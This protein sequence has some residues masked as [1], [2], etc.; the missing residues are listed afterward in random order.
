MHG[1]GNDFVVIDGR[2]SVVD[3]SVDFLRWLA[4]RKRGVGCDQVI[5]LQK[6]ASPL[7]DVHM[8]IFNLDGSQ[9]RA[10]GNATRCVARL[11]FGELGRTTCTIET[12]AALLPAWQEKESQISVDF[13]PPSLA[14]RDIPLAYESDTLRTPVRCGDLSG[15]CCVNVGNPHAVFF[16]PDVSAVA[17]ADLGPRLE[18][19]SLFPDR[20]NIEIAQI[21]SKDRIRMRVWERGSG[22]TDACGSAAC[23]TLV[24]AVRLGLSDRRATLVLDGGDLMIEWRADDHVILTGPDALSFTGLLPEAFASA[25]RQQA[26]R[27]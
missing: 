15:P 24:A 8:A 23:A 2:S 9:A 22:I 13:G 10:C 21:L 6:P 26:P 18:H 16:V 27:A 5:V 3:T 25:Q 7:A 17:L 1:L 19:D 20:C 14:W 4:D 11:M 12:I